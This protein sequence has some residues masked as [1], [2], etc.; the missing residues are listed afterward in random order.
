MTWADP[1]EGWGA[2]LTITSRN[3]LAR[4]VVVVGLLLLTLT[5]ELAP[6]STRPSTPRSFAA[7]AVAD[8]IRLSWEPPLSGTPIVGYVLEAGTQPEAYDFV[9]ELPPVT[10]LSFDAPE[11][12]FYLR[13]SA[14][15]AIGQ[16]PP[17][18][19]VHVVVGT[20]GGIYPGSPRNLTATTPGSL[21]SLNWTEPPPGA[22]PITGYVVRAGTTPGSS[23]V[24]TLQLGLATSFHTAL[25]VIP[26]GA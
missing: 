11:A 17:S 7:T 13:L 24:A 18:G 16:G 3:D 25:N 19:E 14:V 10:S 23:N 21:L 26:A 4:K 2:N 9:V 8:N 15:N 22:L 5:T 20:G 1:A 6:Q 12:V